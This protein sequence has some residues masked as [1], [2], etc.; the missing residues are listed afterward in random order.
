[1]HDFVR[2][3]VQTVIQLS[4][5]VAREL[6]VFDNEC[7]VGANSG[8]ALC[9]GGVETDGFVVSDATTEGFHRL[10]FIVD[11]PLTKAFSFKR[12]DFQ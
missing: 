2:K 9:S 4:F 3:D 10:E 7:I 11:L 5:R 6:N 12:E 8:H 1:M